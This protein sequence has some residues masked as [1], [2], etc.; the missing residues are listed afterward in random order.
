MRLVLRLFGLV[1]AVFFVVSPLIA[2]LAKLRLRPQGDEESDQLDLANIFGGSELKSRA[3]AF[4]GGSIINWYGGTQLDLRGATLAPGGADLAVRDLFGGIDI[5]VPPEWRV[6]LRSRSFAGGSGRQRSPRRPLARCA[7][8]AGEGAFALRRRLNQRGARPPF[9][10]RS[11]G[12]GRSH[13]GRGGSSQR[14]L[15]NRRAAAIFAEAR[16]A[17]FFC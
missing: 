12:R 3:R 7:R 13:L 1:C 6:E 5:R 8:A 16:L 11:A 2:L 14:A 10:G 9:A 17:D 15:D 4:R